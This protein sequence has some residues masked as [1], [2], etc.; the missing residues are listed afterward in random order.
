M[1][2][3]WDTREKSGQGWMYDEPNLTYDAP[4]DPDSGDVVYYNA[5]GS[6]TAWST[7]NKS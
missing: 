1:P 6:T 7:Q 2:T 4:T 3:S 5:L